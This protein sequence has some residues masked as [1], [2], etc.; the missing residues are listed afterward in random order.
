MNLK[1]CNA[2]VQDGKGYLAPCGKIAIA[3]TNWAHQGRGYSGSWP[4]CALHAE[5]YPYQSISE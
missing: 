5:Q 1:R 3:V 2:A 4:V